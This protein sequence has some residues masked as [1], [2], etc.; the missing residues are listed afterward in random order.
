MSKT[1][2]VKIAIQSQESQFS[3]VKMD[4]ILSCTK[5]DLSSYYVERIVRGK[6]TNDR[7][8]LSVEPSD[9][10]PIILP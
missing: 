6:E 9:G 1:S 7:Y 8:S 4:M 2:T 10:Q 3:K 5:H